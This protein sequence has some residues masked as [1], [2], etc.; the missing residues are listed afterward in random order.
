MLFEIEHL[1]RY[2]YTRPVSLDTHVMRFRPLQRSGQ[3]IVAHSL[4]IVPEPGAV[5]TFEDTWGNDAVRVHFAHDTTLLE[6]QAHIAVETSRAA[7]HV[8]H[9]FTLPPPTVAGGTV[10]ADFV[11]PLDSAATLE[12]FLRPL[13]DSAG[14]SGLQLLDALNRAVHAF[15]HHDVRLEGAAQ[16]PA[17]TLAARSGVCR[18]LAVLFMAACRHIGLP[19]RFVSGYQRGDGRRKTRYLHAWPEVYLPADG[20]QGFDPTHG[21]RVADTHV[22]IA[23]GPT[24]ESVAPVVGS[25]RFSGEAPRS[26]LHSE[27]RIDVSD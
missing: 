20:W 19:A 9:D 26:T 1:T 23:A 11:A 4:H 14:R 2:E 13:L 21:E 17:Q 12:D 24:P 6:I 18:D 15:Y 27:V 3:R 25:F 10:A 16:R 8:L 22:A 5:E 7:A